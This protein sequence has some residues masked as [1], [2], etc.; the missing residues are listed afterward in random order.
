MQA[1]IELSVKFFHLCVLA[2]PDEADGANG[3]KSAFLAQKDLQMRKSV[4]ALPCGR[5]IF[6]FNEQGAVFLHRTWS[7]RCANVREI[8]RNP[9]SST[10]EDERRVCVVL[11][12][13]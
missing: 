10:V 13:I 1:R 2:R 9:S 6:A 3:K 11:Q 8:L 5:R 7:D 4:E 12:T